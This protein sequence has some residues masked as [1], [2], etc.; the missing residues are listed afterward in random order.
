MATVSYMYLL[1]S[2]FAATVWAGGYQ[3]CL[4]RVMLFQA[5]EIDALNP[6]SDQTVGFRCTRFNTQTKKC[7]GH[8]EP[9]KKRNNAAGRCD[10]DEMMVHLGRA[11]RQTGWARY[12][13]ATGRLD[14]EATAKNCYRIFAAQGGNAKVP[15][16]QPYKALKGATGEYNDYIMQLSKV[17]NDAWWKKKRD[18]N[19]HQ[20][21]E[22]DSTVRLINIARTGDHGKYLIPAVEQGLG[23]I[24]NI[25]RKSLGNHPVT[26]EGWETVDWKETAAAAKKAG[27][28]DYHTHFT[29]VLNDL[30]RGTQTDNNHKSFR[31]HHQ[32]IRSY[33]RVEDRSRSCR[34]H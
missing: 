20:W 27:V 28:A 34:K 13:A 25:K 3:G 1:L 29:H 30:Y 5:Y 6:P 26:G 19:K 31:D 15:N 14:A 10:F 7:S 33:K 24:M 8:W 22:F 16:F 17:V 11:P 21:A 18:N 9:C 12:N 23:H 32:V 4:E 2:L